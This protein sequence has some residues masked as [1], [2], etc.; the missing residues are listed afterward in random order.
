VG[1]QQFSKPVIKVCSEDKRAASVAFTFCFS[2]H[3]LKFSIFVH[4][5]VD[6]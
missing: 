2:E 6:T 4:N 1:D 3:F 5:G